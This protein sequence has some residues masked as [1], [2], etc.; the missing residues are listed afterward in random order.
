MAK[1]PPQEDSETQ[2]LSP[3]SAKKPMAESPP[4]NLPAIN[5]PAGNGESMEDLHDR[6]LGEF[7]ILRRLGKGGMAEVYLAEQTS[8]KRNVAVKVLRKELVT[9]ESYLKRFKTEATAA[10]TL[11]HPNIVQVYVIGEQDGIQFIAQEYVQGMNLREFLTRK[12][13]PEQAVAIHIMK[14][15]ASA[16]Q[17]A[18]GAGIVHRD[19]KPENIMITRKGDVKVADFGLAQLMQSGE[20]VNL[21]Q[22]GVTMGTPLYMSPEQVNGSKLDQRSDIYSFGVTAYHMLSGNPPFRGETAISVAVQHLKK[23]P[24]PLEKIRGDLP[25]VLC[26]IVQKMMAKDPE[27][28]YQSAQM[29]LKDLRRLAQDKGAEES[30]PGSEEEISVADEPETRSSLPSRLGTRIWTFPDQSIT[31]QI[32]TVLILGLVAGSVSAGVG[33]IMRTPDPRS[34]PVKVVSKVPKKENARLQLL[35]A[36]TLVDD[37]DA[38]QAV[39]DYFPDDRLPKN[40]AEKNL[41]WINLLKGNL[42]EAERFFNR[43]ATDT[44][45]EF[46]AY[47]F[48]GQAVIYNQRGDYAESQKTLDRLLPLYEVL[49]KF[50]SRMQTF[51]RDTIQRNYQGLQSGLDK[52]W[53]ELVREPRPD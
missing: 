13:P 8:L 23:E 40:Y 47:G 42:V 14:Q 49:G 38:W 10:A 5:P 45:Q 31:R 11:S 20:R 36:S 28:R 24:E 41:A 16:L 35:Y 6:M 44:D 48:A 43:F 51:V 4:G 22:V 29:V 21:T 50:D 30:Q 19:I 25:P 53:L 46:R 39:I 18:H 52:R 27:K 9:D 17:A 12:G 1:G 37:I 33:W 3:A 32:I 7:R 15:V 34:T 2:D 26:R